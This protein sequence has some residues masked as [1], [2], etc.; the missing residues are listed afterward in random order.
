ME[1]VAFSIFL[2]GLRPWRDQCPGHKA[3]G[4]FLSWRV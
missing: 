4:F 3:S 1:I 2:E